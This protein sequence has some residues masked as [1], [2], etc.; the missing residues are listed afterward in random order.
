MYLYYVNWYTIDTIKWR[1]C[2][3]I[4]NDGVF[5]LTGNISDHGVMGE[6]DGGMDPWSPQPD[7]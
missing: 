4:N 1:V 7:K 6:G 3:L 5:I 2:N